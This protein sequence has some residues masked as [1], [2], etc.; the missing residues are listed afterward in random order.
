MINSFQIQN[1]EF[2]KQFLLALACLKSKDLST[3]DEK[4][5][6]FNDID[7]PGTSESAEAKETGK[8]KSKK[9]KPLSLRDYE[10]KIILERDGRFS[11]SED[12][13]DA[14]QKAK[15]E[16]P[17]YVEEQNE[18]RDSFKHALKDGNEDEDD[19]LKIRQKTEDEKNKVLS[20]II[21]LIIS[22]MCMYVYI[23]VYN[24]YCILFRRKNRTRSG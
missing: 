18:L 4:V 23:I 1:P 5:K 15:S 2:D 10:R 13:D 21:F 12:E 20:I 17:T 11:S 8:K 24:Y 3:Y 7:K 14:R 22:H 19:L 9:E 16:M 6:S